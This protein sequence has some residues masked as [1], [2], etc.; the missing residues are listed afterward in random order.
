MPSFSK[1]LVS[2]VN[3]HIANTSAAPNTRLKKILWELISNNIGHFE[4]IRPDEVMMDPDNRAKSM[5][6]WFMSHSKVEAIVNSG[7][8]EAALGYK[9]PTEDATEGHMLQIK[10][11]AFTL[12]PPGKDLDRIMQDNQKMVVASRGHLAPLSGKERYTSVATTH[13]SQG[14]KAVK[15]GCPTPL[16]FKGS[17]GGV[18]NS[19]VICANDDTIRGFITNGWMWLVLPFECKEHW[20]ALAGF[21]EMVYNV[22]NTTTHG[23][24]EMEC[25]LEA[26]V[27]LAAQIPKDEVV[28]IIANMRP[29]CSAY[30]KAIV[31]IASR[32]TQVDVI[33][34]QS[35]GFRY[36]NSRV[37]GADFLATINEHEFW[38]GHEHNNIRYF[39]LAANLTA[40]KV[41]DGIAKD[42]VQSDLR[43]LHGRTKADTISTADRHMN[44]ARLLS[45]RADKLG[46]NA[47]ELKDLC[48][49]VG[50]RF[51]NHAIGKKVKRDTVELKTIDAIIAWFCDRVQA[52]GNKRHMNALP[53]HWAPSTAPEPTAEGK[54][55]SEGTLEGLKI[56][57][58]KMRATLGDNFECSSATIE[59][60]AILPFKLVKVERETVQLTR[61][62]RHPD[63]RTTVLSVN[64]SSFVE[65]FKKTRNPPPT[66]LELPSTLFTPSSSNLDILIKVY[67]AI[68]SAEAEA[69]PRIKDKMEFAIKPT[70][71]FSR[72]ALSPNE[73]VL[74]PCTTLALLRILDA[75]TP[76][77]QNQLITY[78][79][80][81]IKALPPKV[82]SQPSSF[83]GIDMVAPFWWLT[84][85]KV[86][87]MVVKRVTI[88]DGI[89]L[90]TFTNDVKIPPFVPLAFP[91]DSNK[92]SHKNDIT[93]ID[94]VKLVAAKAKSDS[95]A[96]TGI[97]AKKAR[98]S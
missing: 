32:F 19:A 29:T 17:E 5:L 60:D 95:S 87:N 84:S 82:P 89:E 26:S 80:H 2:V 38:G 90:P 50:V 96:A 48:F 73:V 9:P 77:P 45:Q 7:G 16:V 51:L 75:D 67:K 25:M 28:S 14:F 66:L 71:V 72:K 11:V 59:S 68:M 46:P 30:I 65:N 78:G 22:Q 1:E 88:D 97:P 93:K 92:A 64:L 4:R 47:T 76:C 79:E 58:R 83:E 8:N 57:E 31:C 54:G 63:Q 53:E 94:G 10:S 62:V 37:L 85:N 23:K 12:P 27:R 15:H 52:L 74:Y 35:W 43:V 33:E 6:D 69:W 42:I 18:F 86:P 70:E 40:E 21:L 24:G 39:A 91:I 44:S 49:A 41:S 61:A 55:N 3:T 20:P 56:I 98:R 13:V 81:R 36:G 34:L